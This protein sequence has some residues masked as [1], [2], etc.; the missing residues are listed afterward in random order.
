M[1]HNGI[2]RCGWCTATSDYIA[3]HDADWGYP[4]ADDQRLFE[5]LSLE[6]FQSGLS[7]L[8]ILNKREGFRVAFHGFDLAKVA[9]MGPEDVERL[10]QDT[11]IVRH[12]GKIEATINNAKRCQELIAQEGSFAAY[13][14]RLEPERTGPGE[15][16]AQTDVSQ[17][18]SKDLKKR[19][20]KFV[21]PTTVYAFMQ[22][23]GM[24]NDH[25]ADCTFRA[26]A[27]EARAAFTPPAG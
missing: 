22:A 18:I 4:V 27:E 16:P 2:E 3:Y 26:K 20:W 12:R 19:G 25:A 10:L 14:W 24:V 6:S 5:K 23:M 13:L 9:A 17:A 1:T 8:T 21:G 11:G 7:W 15:V